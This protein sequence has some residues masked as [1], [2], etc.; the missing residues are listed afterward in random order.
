MHNLLQLSFL[1]FWASLC[2]LAFAGQL[3]EERTDYDVIIEP[4]TS[5]QNHE[6][7]RLQDH[8][9]Q[10]SNFNTNDVNIASCDRMGTLT[11]RS[12][13]K[14]PMDFSSQ[15]FCNETSLEQNI[16]GKFATKRPQFQ[17]RT[18]RP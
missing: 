4:D 16:L 8:T 14:R 9:K 13:T 12:R 2:R 15:K 17:G 1:L 18:I 6:S 10:V 5:Y 7:N 11:K 3:E